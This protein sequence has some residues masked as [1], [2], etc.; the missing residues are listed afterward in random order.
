[1]GAGCHLVD[2]QQSGER[3]GARMPQRHAIL[4]CRARRRPQ[5][6]RLARS[7]VNAV[8]SGG[9]DMT[10]LRIGFLVSSRYAQSTSHVPAVMRALAEAGV[11][12]DVIHPVK[13]ALEL[14]HVR[15]ACDLYLLKKMSRL[16]L[17]LAGAL[18]AQG[19]AIVN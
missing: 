4:R 16:S 1:S 11:V 3:R 9:R 12:V 8:A 6:A 15:V 13:Q 17:S 7:R 2:R 18:H 19:A 14:S 10:P 5:A